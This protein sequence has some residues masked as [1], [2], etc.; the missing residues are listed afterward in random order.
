MAD[1][2]VARIRKYNVPT[3]VPEGN[4]EEH[5]TT[6]TAERAQRIG[7]DVY[8]GALQTQYELILIYM[9][10]VKIYDFE[11]TFFI[12]GIPEEGMDDK[13]NA[14][15]STRADLDLMITRK[16]EQIDKLVGE[17]IAD[18]AEDEDIVSD[19]VKTIGGITMIAVG[20]NSNYKDAERNS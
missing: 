18:M 20:G 4:I 10:L 9:T 6:S 13:M 1:V 3:G 8:T 16:E 12:L 14:K 19:E 17:I 7:S 11:D 5:L 15:H 2:N